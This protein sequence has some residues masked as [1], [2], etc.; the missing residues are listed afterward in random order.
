MVLEVESSYAEQWG[1]RHRMGRLFRHGK[2]AQPGRGPV[3]GPTGSRRRRVL[4]A[5]A[6]GA[7]VVS[8]GGMAAAT[9]VKSPAERAAQT[10]PP[11]RSLLTAAVVSRVLN[12]AVTAR[13]AV[14]P[15]T[16]YD[17]VPVPAS[18]DVTQLYLSGLYV[19]PGDS[20]GSGQLLAEVSGQPLYL[21]K[22]PVPAYRD[23]KPGS[24][25]PDVVELQEALAELGHQAGSDQKGF[26]GPG[27]KRAVTA[28]YR[29]IDH[30]VPV[31]GAATEQAVDAG[32]KAVDAAQQAVDTLTAQRQNDRYAPG[33]DQQL[34]AARRQLATEKAALAKAVAANGPMVPAAHVVF[35]P[36]LPASVTAVTSSVGM[37]VSGA[38]L[39]LSSGGLTVTGQLTPAQAATVVPGMTVE[40]L[41]EETGTRFTGTVAELG[42]LSTTPPAGRVVTIGGT[43]PAAAPPVPT[44]DALPYVPVTVTPAADPPGALSGRN[45]RITIRKQDSGRP[46]TA[47]PVAA[48]S[49]DAAGKTTVTTVNADGDRTTVAVT[50]GVTA[51]GMVAVV[52]A[53]GSELRAG[54]QVV[55]GR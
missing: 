12:P 35:L 53:D 52:P 44:A 34:S 6:T 24:S 25:G 27:T 3:T 29:A 9:L 33:I 39:S 26:F 19:K 18:P 41:A 2:F 43:A 23:L 13:A 31:T 55:V 21:L 5:V 46:V 22:G 20:V 1:W 28:F 45:V 8:L 50:T 32:Q 10:A 54:D 42:A 47:V 14:H 48:I 4:V 37:P 16:R 49:T 15:V 51:E 7:A 30:P 38:L 17:V 11:P 36:A 40:I